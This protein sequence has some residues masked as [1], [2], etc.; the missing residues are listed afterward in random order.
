MARTVAQR[1]K[2]SEGEVQNTMLAGLLHDIGKIG[3]PDSLLDRPFNNLPGPLRAQVMAHPVIGENLLM[4]IDQLRE[5]AL[6]I[7]HHHECFDGSGYP[8][9]LAGDRIPLAAR[10]LAV[11]NDYDAL[12]LGTLSRRRHSPAEALALIID[13]EGVRYDPVI[14]RSFALWLLATQPGLR[15]KM[16]LPDGEGWPVLD[17]EVVEPSIPTVELET[18]DLRV[19]MTL[20][21]DLIH[22]DGYLLLAAGYVLQEATIFHLQR[23][24]QN[25]GKSITVSIREEVGRMT[26]TG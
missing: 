10:I 24:E 20:A 14:V 22:Q 12:Q 25:E 26:E 13:Q 23:M 15:G 21:K 2:L 1:M 8:D 19:G 6:A 3:L 11:V 17:E 16:R 9:R 4:A 5:P 18:K 7:R